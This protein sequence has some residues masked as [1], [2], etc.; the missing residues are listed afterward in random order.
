MDISWLHSVATAIYAPFVRR[1]FAPFQARAA[2]GR[3]REFPD[4]YFADRA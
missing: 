1:K 4:S 2:S 3:P